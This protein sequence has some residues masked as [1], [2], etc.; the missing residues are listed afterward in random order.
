[1]EVNNGGLLGFATLGGGAG[2]GIGCCGGVNVGYL[3]DVSCRKVS[4]SSGEDLIFSASGRES[5]VHQH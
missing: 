5:V 1:M 4:I 3:T 2:V